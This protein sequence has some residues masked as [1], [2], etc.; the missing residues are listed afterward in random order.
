MKGLFILIAALLFSCRNHPHNE[1]KI[2]NDYLD[3]EISGRRIMLSKDADF[4]NRLDTIEADVN[5][6]LFLTVDIENIDASINKTNQY[7]TNT[8][9]ALGI[10]TA[11]FIKLYKGVPLPEIIACIKRNHLSLLNKIIIKRK[12]NGDF[13]YTAQ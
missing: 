5:N 1:Q 12:I 4:T 3:K 9:L 13:L 11:G 6:L 7:F 8:P 2:N 10:D